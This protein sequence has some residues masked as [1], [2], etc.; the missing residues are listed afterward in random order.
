LQRHVSGSGPKWTKKLRPEE[1][2]E[3]TEDAEREAPKREA[4]PKREAPQKSESPRPQKKR[5]SVVKPKIAISSETDDE[6]REE[7]FV[8]KKAKGTEPA[9]FDDD[10]SATVR[11]SKRK[12][13]IKYNTYTSEVT[14]IKRED[15]KKKKKKKRTYSENEYDN[16]GST[17][18]DDYE[19]SLRFDD[20]EEDIGDEILFKDQSSVDEDYELD[21][22]YEDRRN[23][24]HPMRTISPSAKGNVYGRGS[25]TAPVFQ[26]YHSAE[27]EFRFQQHDMKLEQQHS[28]MTS[29]LQMK[30][31]VLENNINNNSNEKVGTF[32]S[33]TQQSQVIVEQFLSPENHHQILNI[34]ST[35]IG[36]VI[37]LQQQMF[38]Q[39]QQ[40]PQQVV[41]VEAVHSSF[42]NTANVYSF[43]EFNSRTTSTLYQSSD[44]F[45]YGRIEQQ[46]YYSQLNSSNSVELPRSPSHAS[47]PLQSQYASPSS[48]LQK[49]PSHSS[50]HSSSPLQP[51]YAS[52]SPPSQQVNSLLDL[53]LSNVP[54]TFAELSPESTNRATIYSAYSPFQANSANNYNKESNIINNNNMRNNVD[55][56]T[57]YQPSV[58][59][60]SNLQHRTSGHVSEYSNSQENTSIWPKG[61]D[62]LP[63]LSEIRYKPEPQ[64]KQ[65]QQLL[66]QQQKQKLRQEQQQEAMYAQWA[67]QQQQ[68]QRL[69]QQNILQNAL[70]MSSTSYLRGY[71]PNIPPPVSPVSPSRTSPVQTPSTQVLTRSRSLSP[72]ANIQQ[73]RV[74]PPKSQGQLTRSS[75]VS[76]A[77]TTTGPIS[78][79]QSINS[80]PSDLSQP[81]KYP[82]SM[83][84]NNN[85]NNNNN[86]NVNLMDNGLSQTMH[87]SPSQ[88]L[89]SGLSQ[90]YQYLQPTMQNNNNNNY[91][92]NSNNNSQSNSNSN[93]PVHPPPLRNSVENA[94]IN[95]NYTNNIN[96]NDTYN[97]V[98]NPVD[99]FLDGD[100]SNKYMHSSHQPNEGSTAQNNNNN[101]YNN[102]NTGAIPSPIIYSTNTNYN[103]NSSI[104]GNSN[105]ASNIVYA[106]EGVNSTNSSTQIEVYGQYNGMLSSDG[107]LKKEIGE[108]MNATNVKNNVGNSSHSEVFE[109]TD[110][111]L[112]DWTSIFIDSSEG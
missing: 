24:F 49:N 63:T 15:G 20:L 61:S 41:P 4:L 58:E 73:G 56:G 64:R 46:Q 34:P 91:N 92:I 47:S 87:S 17:S 50:S 13:S 18:T 100:V 2:T 107:T 80:S 65:S 28:H 23:P 3:E 26:S 103:N 11:R 42:G 35:I 8:P 77:A 45:D 44:P 14:R 85:I 5:K 95:N 97:T 43:P 67:L 30:S 25:P 33:Y 62:Q 82:Q 86:Y 101:N 38:Q 32:P 99:D 93:S 27:N 7:E 29:H 102:N 70:Q 69:Y 83:I 16:S 53:P 106:I 37:Q 31:P 1:E 72:T 110:S 74:S 105:N 19:P 66:Q 55:L 112:S 54:N 104:Q 108:N 68:Q 76:T 21:E 109:I 22:E 60:T 88:M 90:S 96:N 57:G 39:Q 52:P 12:T 10:V 71:S 94:N 51:Q 81:Y 89:N 59:N 9:T 84:Q 75:T 98:A 78:Q 6:D 36:Q 48:P 79:Y 111:S 40:S